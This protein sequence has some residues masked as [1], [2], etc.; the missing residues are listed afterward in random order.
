MELELED[1]RRQL[2]ELVRMRLGKRALDPRTQA[3]YD[4]L[5]G[6]ERQLL[7]ERAV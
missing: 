7:T 1:V 4:Y 6:R 2:G 5:I 3:R